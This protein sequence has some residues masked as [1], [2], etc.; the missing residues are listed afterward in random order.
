MAHKSGVLVRWTNLRNED[1]GI[2][3]PHFSLCCTESLAYQT[4]DT[5]TLHAFSVSFADGNT[6]SRLVGR[7]VYHRQRRGK[8]AFPFLEKPLEIRLFF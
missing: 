8:G 2:R 5:V 1:D 7:T 3:A 4:F 6:H